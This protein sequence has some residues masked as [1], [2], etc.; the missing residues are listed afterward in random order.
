MKREVRGFMKG[1][2]AIF[3]VVALMVCAE[4]TNMSVFAAEEAAG[5]ASAGASAGTATAAG[6]TTGTIVAG[7]VVAAAAVAIVASSGGGGGST[8]VTPEPGEAV[9]AALNDLEALDP[10]LANY[11]GQLGS[12]SE[13]QV[14]AIGDLFAS[15]DS[16]ET[17]NQLAGY[18]ANMTLADLQ[19][20][21]TKAEFQAFLSSLNATIAAKIRAALDALET[22]EQIQ[23][24]ASV[25][26]KVSSVAELNALK[27][28]GATMRDKAAEFIA[29]AEKY[30][31]GETVLPPAHILPTSHHSTTTH[32]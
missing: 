27:K 22:L 16:V 8:D 30:I 11:V 26:S 5:A 31:E 24:L 29:G 12:L 1:V 7:A 4:G 21:A 14:A 19:S 28:L 6:I 23:L 10:A 32:H 3:L 2:T 13:A 25:L 15:L 18:L 9:T 20:A 17:A